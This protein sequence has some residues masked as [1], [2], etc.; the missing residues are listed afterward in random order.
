MTG[1]V[2]EETVHEG[3]FTRRRWYMTRTVY[4]GDST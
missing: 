4:Q 2:Y 1:T 3:D